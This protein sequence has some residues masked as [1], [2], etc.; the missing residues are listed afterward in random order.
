MKLLKMKRLKRS[1][2]MPA[3]DPNLIWTP[4]N[5]E[6]MDRPGPGD[7]V[8]FIE[9]H[10]PEIARWRVESARRRI[11]GE[12]GSDPGTGGEGRSTR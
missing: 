2:G 11:R 9:S 1:T 10:P 7:T 8:I 5:F 6:D 4:P 12:G 3:P